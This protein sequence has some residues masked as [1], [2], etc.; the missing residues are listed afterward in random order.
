MSRKTHPCWRFTLIQVYH[1][2]L[3]IEGAKSR[4]AFG[5]TGSEG[6]AAA[7]ERTPLR[8]YLEPMIKD[9]AFFAYS[10]RDVPA[11]TAF[12]RDVVGLT[13]GHAFGEHWIE[14]DVGSTTFG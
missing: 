12:Y 10:V 3:R 4:A 9:M 5:K 8:L 6:P 13:P 7:Q 1:T 2:L 11:A 14:F